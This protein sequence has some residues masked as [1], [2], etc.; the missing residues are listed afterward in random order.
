MNPKEIFLVKYNLNEQLSYIE[1][2]NEK[3]IKQFK[4][5]EK[6]VERINIELEIAELFLR[7]KK[8]LELKDE[9]LKKIGNQIFNK[10]T[11]NAVKKNLLEEIQWLETL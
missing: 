7:R 1:R 9:E 10:Q 11:L 2:L 3:S 5:I 8:L 6:E 4:Q